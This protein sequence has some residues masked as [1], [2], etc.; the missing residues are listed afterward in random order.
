M[1]DFCYRIKSVFCILDAMAEIL[2]Q[3]ARKN[4]TREKED[5]AAAVRVSLQEHLH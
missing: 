3:F 2:Q 1:L 5:A 4:E